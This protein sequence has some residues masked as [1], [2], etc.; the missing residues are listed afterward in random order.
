MLRY[1]YLQFN[2]S[3]HILVFIIITSLSS[4]HNAHIH[5]T[6]RDEQEVSHSHW[7]KANKYI[8]YLYIFLYSCWK[9]SLLSFTFPPFIP[10]LL[11]FSCFLP[12]GY[13]HLSSFLYLHSLLFPLSKVLYSQRVLSP[14]TS[15]LPF[16]STFSYRNLFSP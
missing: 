14:A 13:F 11:C 8:S 12:P 9:T 10:I 4:I 7:L 2:P 3:F 5:M 1:S 16:S 15:P 6:Q